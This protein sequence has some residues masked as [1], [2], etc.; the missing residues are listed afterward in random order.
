MEADLRYILN[1]QPD[2]TAA[3][4]A[5]G[6]TFADRNQHLDEALE[7][8]QKAYDLAPNDPAIIDSL[9]W[10]KYRLGDTETALTLLR[11]AY[12][13]YKDQEIAAHLGEVLWITGQKKEARDIW[14]EALENNPDSPAIQKVMDRFLKQ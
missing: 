8:I 11:Q 12:S 7:L 2:H 9:A 6:Y 1:E 5:L 14:Q 10:V 13:A 3:L 4:N